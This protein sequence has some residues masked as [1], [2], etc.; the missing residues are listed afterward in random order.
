MRSIAILALLAFVSMETTTV[1]DAADPK[2]KMHLIDITPA[3]ADAT[4]TGKATITSGDCT[5]EKSGIKWDSYIC[6]DT[7]STA[8]TCTPVLTTLT[9]TVTLT[10]GTTP[11]TISGSLTTFEKEK[12]VAVPLKE[13]T[14][15]AGSLAF[16]AYDTTGTNKP[17]ACKKSFSSG[18]GVTLGFFALILSLLI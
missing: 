10:C 7:A 1:S 18:L 15:D 5:A 11:K 12:E 8:D 9:A 13:G 2:I 3:K 17:R 14:T 6:I 4:C 16:I